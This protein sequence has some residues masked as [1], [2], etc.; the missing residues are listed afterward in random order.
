MRSNYSHTKLSQFSQSCSLSF[1]NIFGCC[2][3]VKVNVEH[4]HI[5]PLLPLQRLWVEIRP[6]HHCLS[7][8]NCESWCEVPNNVDSFVIYDQ[9]AQSALVGNVGFFIC[10]RRLISRKG[11]SE[12]T[13][14]R[15]PKEEGPHCFTK[16]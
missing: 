1:A 11:F 8:N 12:S 10:G 13:I 7:V 14:P 3:T 16:L 5:G 15:A 4:A 2:V 9:A 6:T